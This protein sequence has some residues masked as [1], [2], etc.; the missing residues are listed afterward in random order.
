M[1]STRTARNS[2]RSLRAPFKRPVSA[3]PAVAEI[4]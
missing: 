4:C 1:A 3:V 2:R